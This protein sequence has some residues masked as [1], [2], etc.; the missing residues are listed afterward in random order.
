[1]ELGVADDLVFKRK[2]S[3]KKDGAV[4]ILTRGLVDRSKYYKE[5][6]I[7]SLVPFINK[8]LSF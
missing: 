2:N 7:M 5:A 6:V 3:K 8:S 1:V 4:G